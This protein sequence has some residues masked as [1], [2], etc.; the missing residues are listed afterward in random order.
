MNPK[1]SDANMQEYKD[2]FMMWDRK[3][4]SKIAVPHIGH[5]M[6]SLL[7]NPTEKAIKKVIGPDRDEYDRVDWETFLP[8]M[9]DVTAGKFGNEN[10]FVE[11]LKVFDKDNSSTV[12]CG[13][14]RHV[15]ST[16]G[17]RLEEAEVD[18]I[19]KGMEDKKGMIQIDE[20]AAKL[21]TNH[22]EQE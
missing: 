6:R 20:L 11:G 22:F 2:T 1:F 15:L 8:M 17:E 13:E 16:L 9:K 5:V 10:D 14:I 19:I 4:D 18:V 21:L 7:W 12:N 3:G